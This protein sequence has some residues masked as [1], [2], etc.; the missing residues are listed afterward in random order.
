MKKISLLLLLSLCMI[1]IYGQD[2][3]TSGKWDSL[4][5]AG[6]ELKGTKPTKVYTYKNG[7]FSFNY[8]DGYDGKNK[9]IWLTTNSGIFDYNYKGGEKITKVLVG[10][11]RDGKLV[12]KKD[13]EFVT[14]DDRETIFYGDNFDVTV[15]IG[16]CLREGLSLRFV[17]P[18]YSK[19]D[20]DIFVPTT[21]CVI[22][23]P[24]K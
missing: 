14:T 8:I 6:D 19:T 18:R 13:L 23:S 11:Y 20:F 10:Y 1:N 15:M 4:S 17:A 22:V 2:F 9:A 3:D 12:D 24:S 7:D 5:M 21:K 16:I